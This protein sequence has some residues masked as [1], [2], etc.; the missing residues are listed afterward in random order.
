MVRCTSQVLCPDFPPVT[1]TSTT[2]THMKRL[3][4]EP[5]AVRHDLLIEDSDGGKLIG[6]GGAIF[7]QLKAPMKTR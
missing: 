6:Q 5:G 1:A 7:K 2:Q 3:E 4:N